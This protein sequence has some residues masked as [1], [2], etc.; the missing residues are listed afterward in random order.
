MVNHEGNTMD[1]IESKI[2]DIITIYESKYPNC[3]VEV[4]FRDVECI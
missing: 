1:E 3:N 4:R 2:D